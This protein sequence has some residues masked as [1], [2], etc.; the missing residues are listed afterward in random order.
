M[1]ENALEHYKIQGLEGKK[2][3][4]AMLVLQSAIAVVV[5]SWQEPSSKWVRVV[6]AS[7]QS[8]YGLFS[9]GNARRSSNYDVMF[10]LEPP[11][12]ELPPLQTSFA[13]EEHL[14]PFA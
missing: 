3:C 12:D 6:H 7:K 10:F 4:L 13:R 1:K 9:V 2:R 5:W 11:W 8:R 14:L